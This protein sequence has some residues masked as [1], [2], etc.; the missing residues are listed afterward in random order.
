[1]TCALALTMRVILKSLVEEMEPES[2]PHSVRRIR[3]FLP[4]ATRSVMGAPWSWGYVEILTPILSAFLAHPSFFWI[5]L[6]N[7]CDCGT[8]YCI[9]SDL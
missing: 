3:D 8:L 9:A 6:D 5:L 1:M 4:Y 7:I 2:V